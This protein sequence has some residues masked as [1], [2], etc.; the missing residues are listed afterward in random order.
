MC[1]V[2]CKDIWEI[3]SNEA[4]QSELVVGKCVSSKSEGFFKV[5]SPQGGSKQS[6]ERISE[7][8]GKHFTLV[9][10]IWLKR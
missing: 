2:F 8:K 6:E 9:C 5:G 1:V 10:V 3:R 4:A 7:W